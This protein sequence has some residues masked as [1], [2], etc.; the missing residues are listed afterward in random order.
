V[1]STLNVH[2]FRRPYPSARLEESSLGLRDSVVIGGNAIFAA[3]TDAARAAD[4]APPAPHRR[5]HGAWS[6][7]PT[8]AARLLEAL[9]DRVELDL[10]RA[11][12]AVRAVV[13][14]VQHPDR[15]GRALT[16][17]RSLVDTARFDSHSPLRDAAGRTRRLSGMALPFEEVRALKRALGGS[18]IDVILTLMTRAMRAWH[19]A[20]RLRVDELMTLV[21]V[22]LRTPEQ[23]AEQA[24]V[25]NVATGILVPLPLRIADPLA[26]YREVHARMEA[27]KAD[28]A[29][30]AAP[31]LAEAMSLLPRQLVTWFSQASFSN[32]DFIVTNVPGILV[33]RYLAGAE[34]TA[35]YPF[36]PV[37]LHSPASVALYGYRDQLFIGLNSDAAT[38][39]DAEHF[40]HLIR[41][42][43]EELQAALRKPARRRQPLGSKPLGRKAV[44]SKAVAS[45]P[46][47]SKPL[48][49]K[50]VTHQP[51]GRKPASRTSAPAARRRR[52][53]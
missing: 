37:A 32:L 29:S 6:A 7:E 5:G 34:I 1:F 22:N 13:D 28:P 49:S 3:M 48:G 36:A 12:G 10:E 53:R 42:A 24:H 9:R 23:W 25:G 33:P 4:D 35:A 38:M 43:F 27:K 20:H 46:V 21:P 40:Q 19:R 31:L 50:P 45:K 14:T 15:L 41:A 44:G 26:T 47:G 30:G 51:T 8:V 11:R 18:M 2:A 17:L 39:P 52:A 16:A